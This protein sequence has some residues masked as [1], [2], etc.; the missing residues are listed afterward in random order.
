MVTYDPVCKYNGH[1]YYRVY[2]N[3]KFVQTCDEGELSEVVRE[4]EG[5]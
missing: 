2:V 1:V 3:G 5:K 4:L